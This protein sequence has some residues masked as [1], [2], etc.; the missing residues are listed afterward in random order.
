[1]IDIV[2]TPEQFNEWA[3]KRDLELIQ[4]L[5][6]FRVGDIVTYTNEFGISFENRLIV[7]ISKTNLFYDRRFYIAKDAYWFPVKTEEIQKQ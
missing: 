7:G 2:E 1:M 3:N 6:G 4:E 5:D